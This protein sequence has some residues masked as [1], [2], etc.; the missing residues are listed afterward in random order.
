MIDLDDAIFYI[1]IFVGA[2]FVAVG[3]ANEWQFWATYNRQRKVWRTG[4]RW[5]RSYR[6]REAK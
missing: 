5:W 6:E 4:D 2:L 3:I 1:A